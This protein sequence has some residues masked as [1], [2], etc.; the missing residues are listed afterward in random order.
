MIKNILNFIG[1]FI[2]GL[3]CWVFTITVLFISISACAYIL[4][5]LSMFVIIESI[6]KFI[7]ISIVAIGIIIAIIILI[8]EIF[9][10]GNKYINKIK[11]KFKNKLNK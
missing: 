6:F 10:T 7:F 5:A 4:S 11:K 8:S 2:V 9:D 3:I 1:T